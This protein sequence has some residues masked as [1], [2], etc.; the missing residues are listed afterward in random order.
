MANEKLLTVDRVLLRGSKLGEKTE[1]LRF[2]VPCIPTVRLRIISRLHSL[3]PYAAAAHLTYFSSITL[4]CR[5][6]IQQMHGDYDM[7]GVQVKTCL[8]SP[9]HCLFWILTSSILNLW[10]NRTAFEKCQSNEKIRSQFGTRA[11]LIQSGVKAFSTPKIY[12]EILWIKRRSPLGASLIAW[13]N[14]LL[15]QIWRMKHLKGLF[16]NHF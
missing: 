10:R 15:V 14:V 7:W 2:D 3:F 16:S 9:L 4:F 1:T 12:F 6:E 11:Y 5:S 8:F 13:W